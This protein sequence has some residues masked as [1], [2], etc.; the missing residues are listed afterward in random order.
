MESRAVRHRLEVEEWDEKA[1]LWLRD[2]EELW[3][4]VGSGIRGSPHITSLTLSNLCEEAAPVVLRALRDSEL[5]LQ[6]LS[7][8]IDPVS[9]T[10]SLSEG[11]LLPQS[12]RRHRLQLESLDLKSLHVLSDEHLVQTL[13]EIRECSKLQRLC[14]ADTDIAEFDSYHRLCLELSGILTDCHGLREIDLNGT[15][16]FVQGHEQIVDEGIRAATNLTKLHCHSAFRFAPASGAW[17]LQAVTKCSSLKSLKVERHSGLLDWAAPN[18]Q[19]AIGSFMNLKRLRYLSLD[20]NCLDREALLG[21]TVALTECEVL[22]ELKLCFDGEINC[23][24]ARLLGRNF[25]R[26]P[27][28]A[29]LI[30]S[31]PYAVYREKRRIEATQTP[32]MTSPA[33]SLFTIWISKCL[34]LRVLDIATTKLLDNGIP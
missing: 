20:N 33:A 16:I 30:L 23:T 26:M 12:I 28:L 13:T 29:V 3:E 14:L 25:G 10:S 31:N 17:L 9:A 34:N 5:R 4:C 18:T 32:R 21:L 2:A 11:G 6:H 22:Q 27:G 1:Q 8:R 7:L 24:T 19:G 15:E